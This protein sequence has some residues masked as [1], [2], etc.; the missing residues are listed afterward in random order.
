MNDDQ[1]TAGFPKRSRML[2]LLSGALFLGGMA[3]GVGEK[4]GGMK[5]D[6][7]KSWW[8]LQP[9][10][11]P[12]I[13]QATTRGEIDAFLES[14]LRTEQV[15][16]AAPADRRT[17]LRRATY[18]LT[19]LPP[20]MDEMEAFQN[21]GSPDAFAK[22][23]DRLLTSPR[24]GEQWGR[25]WLDVVR[26]A[27][28]AGDNTDRPLPHIWRYRNWVID[29]FNRDMPYDEFVRLQLAGD[30]LRA[31]STGPAHSEGIVATGY[32]ALARRFGHDSD[33]DMH[34]THEDVIDT[35]GKS[36]L[37][38]TLGCARC[39]D[40]K[41]D[42]VST[43][44]YYALYGIFA[45]SRFSF[46]GCEA[47]GQPRDL[48]PILTESDAA[49]LKRPW[50][51]AK[52]RHE[53]RLRELT[54]LASGNRETWK[55]STATAALLAE[56][57][58]P[59]GKSAEFAAPNE[60]KLQ[61]GDCLQLVVGPQ[62]SHGADST[63]MAWEITEVGGKNRQW[64]LADLIPKLLEANLR[65]SSQGGQWYFLGM[66]NGPDFLSEP[67]SKVMGHEELQEWRSGSE[68]MV[69]VNSSD[70]VVA[71]WVK[72]PA[73]AF[74]MHPGPKQPVI[75]GWICPDDCVVR[76]HG[77]ATDAHPGGP[78]GVTVRLEHVKGAT[79]SK[80][81]VAL[82]DAS[83]QHSEISRQR[84]AEAG[85]EPTVP[86]AFAVVEGKPTN[87]KVQEKGDPEKLGAEVPRHWLTVLGGAPVA[88]DAG[89]GRRELA[90]WIVEQPLS[91]RVLVNRVWQWHFGQG[92]VRTPNDFGARGEPPTHPELLEWLCGKFIE[93][94]RSLKSLHRLIM[95]SAAYQRGCVA[96]AAPDPENK[97]FGRFNPRRLTAEEIR[98]SLLMMSGKLDLQP[99]EAHPFPPEATWTFTQHGPFNAVYDNN[100]RSVFQMVQRQRRHPFLALFD[101]AD[102]NASTAMRQVTTVPTQALYFLN[103][104]FFH[105]KANECALQILRQPD[106]TARVSQT[107]RTL[108]QRNPTAEDSAWI[109]N[110]L[111]TYPGPTEQRW[112]ACV[113]VLLAGNEFL[114]L[115]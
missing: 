63:Q 42:P 90:E 20:T 21:D 110:F 95:N 46:A 3:L 8:S 56:V 28:T 86:V 37:G 36:M 49:A 18:D 38:L 73:Q 31:A 58:V 65:Q 54:A 75:V 6:V 10:K 92:L 94:G 55:Q 83:Q 16:M 34:L 43:Q 82:H 60:V 17:L 96:D 103:D 53:P 64:A 108:F 71:A 93:Q 112:A 57:A 109:T 111:A 87:A 107:V 44:D 80:A 40:H 29:A 19:G 104:P 74:I 79:G 115:D 27:D 85:P 101:G 78:D 99:G 88:A 24:Y 81:L 33:K 41:Y 77:K 4:L 47:K 72:L 113:R 39:H 98:D 114:H 62:T 1:L 32:L 102:P 100:K 23:V 89:S 35:M 66:E 84:D 68:P 11:S 30:I 91:T 13:P 9:L 2:V 76:I 5:L 97:W 61:A 67:L 15:P 51:E 25:H 69:L 106:D 52:A 26:Y 105:A 12:A 48:M 59:E 14:K 70:H 22:V 50:L 7:A 45:S